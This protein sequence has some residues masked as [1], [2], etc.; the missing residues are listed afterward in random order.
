MN[1]VFYFGEKVKGF[2]VRVLNE[3]EVRASAGILFFLAIFSFSS[4]W[5]T[6]NFYPTK[7]FVVGFL[8]DFFVRIFVNPKYA[9]SLVVGRFI[10][11]NQEPEYVGAPQKRFAWAMGFILAMIMFV[12]AVMLNMMGP[13]NLLICVICLL[14]LFFESAFG[15]CLGCKMY[16]KFSKDEAKLCPGGTCEVKKRVDI[17]KIN[18][19]QIIIVAIFLV[20]IVLIKQSGV[21]RDRENEKIPESEEKS[22]G[23]IIQNGEDWSPGGCAIPDWV[24]EIGHEEKYKKHHS[25]GK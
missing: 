16:N 12:L 5:F 21:I 1:K 9:P 23:V 10:V 8:I 25:C 6:G 7:L 15:I 24:K 3:R 18:L 4:A 14:L 11:N 17:Q 13:I 19:T 20:V 22:E 2:D